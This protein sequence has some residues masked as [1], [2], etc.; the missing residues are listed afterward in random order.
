MREERPADVRS[1]RRQAARSGARAR[2]VA[3]RVAWDRAPIYRTTGLAHWY[4][5]SHAKAL[6]W[7]AKAAE[8]AQKLGMKPELARIYR[9][10]GRHLA[11]A[12]SGPGAFEGQNGDAWLEKA[13]AISRELE[14]APHPATD[15][16]PA[17]D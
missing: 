8:A 3:G 2:R 17:A 15:A 13:A 14:I 7:W 10:I 1:L 9:D 12:G 11:E 5:G 6:S 16:E 4:S